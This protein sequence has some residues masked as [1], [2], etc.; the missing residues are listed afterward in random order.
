MV[1]WLLI[2]SL[3]SLRLRE[4]GAGWW[5][6]GS[7]CVKMCLQDSYA[8]RLCFLVRRIQQSGWRFSSVQVSSSLVRFGSVRFDSAG[9]FLGN[10]LVGL[11][12]VGCVLAGGNT[13]I[14]THQGYEY[15]LGVLLVWN[16]SVVHAGWKGGGHGMGWV[17]W[18]YFHRERAYIEV[19]R[20]LCGY[21]VCLYI[22]FR[23]FFL[24]YTRR[25][26]MKTKNPG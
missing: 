9:V 24:I 16:N 3:R 18:C 2:R 17:W 22:G 21:I 8:K 20:S 25:E 12:E 4:S 19:F 15:I 23:C 14:H 7:L 10:L 13:A 26:R 6:P 11:L 5:W 1:R